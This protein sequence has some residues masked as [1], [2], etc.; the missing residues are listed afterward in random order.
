MGRNIV[1]FLVGLAICVVLFV[2]IGAF[3]DSG[4]PS[5]E[6]TV[7]AQ[8]EQRAP[9]PLPT[10]ESAKVQ[11]PVATETNRAETLNQSSDAK[12][13]TEPLNDPEVVAPPVEEPEVE[14]SEQP[15]VVVPVVPEP[16]P[17]ALAEAAKPEAETQKP[18][19]APE[20]KVAE[21]VVAPE[22]EPLP[23]PLIRQK[24]AEA[25]KAETAPVLEPAKQ[26]PPA[27]PVKVAEPVIPET[28]QP[29][30]ISPKA[31]TVE[32]A[33]IV[34]VTPNPPIAVSEPAK[35]V[36]PSRLP[37]V[38]V[39][40]GGDSTTENSLISRTRSSRL[41]SVSASEEQVE[42]VQPVELPAPAP[43]ATTAKRITV[44]RSSGTGISKVALVQPDTAA[45]KPAEPEAKTRAIDRF[46]I[47]FAPGEKPAMAIILI[48][49][50]NDG[51][52]LNSVATIDLPLSFAVPVDRSDATLAAERY[53]EN[54]HEVLALSPRSVELSLSGGQTSEQVAD[55]LN[56]FFEITPQ[57]VGLMDVSEATL[58]N[59]RV[60]SKYV[61]DHLSE[62]GHGL[63]TYEQ[64]LNAAKREADKIGVPAGLVFRVL[65]Q[66][67]ETPESIARNLDRAA[68]EAARTGSVV[69]VGTTREQTIQAILKWAKTREAQAVDL[70]PVSAA[71]K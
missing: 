62:T 66:K 3:Y 37:V 17:E 70:A 23:A 1:G 36:Q 8:T 54:G 7:R 30:P 40:S 6:T 68:L 11:N 57:A 27:A 15:A 65:D 53:A 67:G 16:A 51:A 35:P 13:P 19:P 41:P 59:D 28:K 49:V 39:G 32:T 26:E 60:L 38:G 22:P 58:Q 20:E 14:V 47:D 18:A 31:E 69:V 12:K 2:A 4:T 64:G 42:T 9:V 61:L 21:I 34:P 50:G 52:P 43:T 55:L 63:V 25:P 5:G 29:E 46:G 56:R 48:D 10:R 71:I 24:P 45:E 44:P 33:T